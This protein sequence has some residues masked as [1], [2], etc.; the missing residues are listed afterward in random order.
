MCKY[1]DKDQMTNDYTNISDD[2]DTTHM[3]GNYYDNTYVQANQQQSIAGVILERPDYFT[4]PSI[5]DLGSKVDSKGDCYVEDFS[6]GRVDYGCIT[7][8]GVTNVANLNLDEIGKMRS[9]F[10]FD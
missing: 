10:V 6:I 7:F 2:D 9:R 5:D 1:F 3:N 4:L 8:P